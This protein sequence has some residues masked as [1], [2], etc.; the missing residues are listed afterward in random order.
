MGMHKIF[1]GHAPFKYFGA[2][3]P[4]NIRRLYVRQTFWGCRAPKYLTDVC[5]SK[6]LRVYTPEITDAWACVKYLTN[7]HLSNI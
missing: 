4:P 1:D 6:M 2:V 5:L 7:M 3:D